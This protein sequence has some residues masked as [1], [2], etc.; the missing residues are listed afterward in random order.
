MA[1]MCDDLEPMEEDEGV[2]IQVDDV[3]RMSERE[4]AY[5]A[6][7]EEFAPLLKGLLA[8]TPAAAERWITSRFPGS[9]QSGVRLLWRR[10]LHHEKVAVV[11]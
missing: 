6:G 8:E 2:L 1:N 11:A 5:L 10:L 7:T 3:E 9:R 4:L